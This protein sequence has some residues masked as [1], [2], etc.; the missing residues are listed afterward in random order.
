MLSFNSVHHRLSFSYSY[1]IMASSETT[2]TA[3]TDPTAQVTD[4]DTENPTTRSDEKSFSSLVERHSCLYINTNSSKH[5]NKRKEAWKKVT[6]DYGSGESIEEIKKKWLNIRTTYGR[7]LKANSDS[8]K[9][10][11]DIKGEFRHLDFISSMMRD[12]KGQ[13]YIQ[14]ASTTSTTTTPSTQ[15]NNIISAATPDRKST[16]LNSSH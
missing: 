6:E 8:I 14:P 3:N 16:R 2:N 12:S 4:T 15:E 5:A 7:Y 13:Q 10:T 9:T 1:S 11:K